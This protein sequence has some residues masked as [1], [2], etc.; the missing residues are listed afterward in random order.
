MAQRLRNGNT[1]IVT[2]HQIMEITREG[3]SAVKPVGNP[4]GE[5]IMR[6]QKLRNGD[7]ALVTQGA[8]LRYVRLDAAGKEKHS[9]PVNVYTS[10]GRIEVLSNGHVLVPEMRANRVIEYDVN[11][12]AVRTLEAQQPIAAVRLANGNTLITSMT[13]NR[14]VELDKDGKQVWEYKN[15]T[16]VTRAWR[17]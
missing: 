15:E 6:A 7:I 11:G 14:A 16:R 10:G 2:R 4:N 3:K 12:A 1:F 17:R 13:E 8:S 9:F 5:F